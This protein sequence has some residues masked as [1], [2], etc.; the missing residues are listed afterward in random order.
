MDDG[1]DVEL[2]LQRN[3]IDGERKAPQG[4]S[5]DVEMNLLVETGV[6]VDLV[7]SLLHLFQERPAEAGAPLFVPTSVLP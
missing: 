1:E 7:E 6:L 5:A 3:E 4:R 2:V